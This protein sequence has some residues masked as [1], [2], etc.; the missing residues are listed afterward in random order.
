MTTN[1]MRLEKGQGEQARRVVTASII[2]WRETVDA[3]MPAHHAKLCAVRVQKRHTC[4]MRAV[5]SQ[6]V[7]RTKPSIAAQFLAHTRANLWSLSR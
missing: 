7:T 4:K 2:K 1:A 5:N 6:L 3:K